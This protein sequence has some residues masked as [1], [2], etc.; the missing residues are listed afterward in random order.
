MSQTSAQTNAQQFPT[1]TWTAEPGN[2]AQFSVSN[3]GFR[4]VRGGV[5]I[6]RCDV[7]V[8]PDGRLRSAVAELDLA[9]IDTGNRRRDLDLAK[10]K[11]LDLQQFPLLVVDVGAGSRRGV[12]TAHGCS[13]PVDLDLTIGDLTAQYVSIRVSTAFDRADLGIKAPS[14]MIGR[15]VSVDFTVRF[16]RA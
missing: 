11:L 7:Q 4:T 15:R 5:P 6:R 9:A 3:F 2:I 16:V 8:E 12:L 13:I 1:G 10:P 14:V